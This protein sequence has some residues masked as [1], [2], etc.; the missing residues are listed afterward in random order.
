MKEYN[1]ADLDEKNI[2]ELSKIAAEVGVSDEEKEDSNK[3]N[4]HKPKKMVYFSLRASWKR[5]M[6]ALAF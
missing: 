3:H 4:L 6:M 5:L 1:L 2:T